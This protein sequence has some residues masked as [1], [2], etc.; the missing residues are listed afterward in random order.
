MHDQARH[1]LDWC[2]R[3]L[4]PFDGRRV[5]DV[6]S[7]DINGNNR[8]YF[9]PGCYTGCDLAPGPNVDV[10]SPCHELPFEPAT[11]DVII[12]SEC[13][14]HGPTKPSSSMSTTVL[15]SRLLADHLE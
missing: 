10:V 11:F 14:E 7:G 4:G 9:G 13:L 5:L 12:S 15:V 6:G 8:Q 1:F 3:H 2:V